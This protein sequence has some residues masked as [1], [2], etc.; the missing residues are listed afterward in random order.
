MTNNWTQTVIFIIAIV[1]GVLNYDGLSNQVAETDWWLKSLCAMTGMAVTLSLSLYW[2]Y[3]FG[4]VPE[5]LNTQKRIQGWLTTLAGVVMIIALSTYWNVVSLSGGTINKLTSASLISKIEVQFSQS[6]KNAQRFRTYVADTNV[7]QNDTKSLQQGEISS[8]GSSGTPKA[9]SVSNTMGQVAE[10]LETLNK[11][12]ATASDNLDGLQ[13]QGTICLSELRV[14]A[15]NGELDAAGKNLSCL[16]NIVAKIEAQ[17]IASTMERS[18]KNL[19]SGVVIPANIRTKTQRDVIDRFLRDIGTRGKKIASDIAALPKPKP[20]Q[21]LTLKRPNV[22]KGVLEHW[23]SIIPAIA[24]ALGIDLLPL[25]LLLFKTIRFDDQRSRNAPKNAWTG[26]ELADALRQLDML[27]NQ[28]K[29]P[30]HADTPPQIGREKLLDVPDYIDIDVSPKTLDVVE[31]D[32]SIKDNTPAF[33]DATIDEN[34]T[35]A[36]NQTEHSRLEQNDEGDK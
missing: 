29:L 30:Q 18:L 19:A 24:T 17:N 5:L 16:N 6:I 10:R 11:S 34:S 4:T 3:A 25:I 7:L 9:G 36:S 33:D 26:A 32:M 35:T 14:K 21:A 15:N 8:G 20:S 1:S 12:I 27:T 22:M 31:A 28:Q 13:Q 2:N 23:Q